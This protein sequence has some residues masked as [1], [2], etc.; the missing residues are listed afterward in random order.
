METVLSP[1]LCS[2]PMAVCGDPKNRHG[3]VLAKNERAKKYGIQTAETIWQAKRKCPELVLVLPHHSEYKKYS[4]QIN[5]IYQR[6]TDM[7]EPFGI[8]ESWL[9]VTGSQRLFGSGFEIAERLRR[10][11]REETGLTISVG[12]SF[13]KTFAKLGSDYKKPNATTVIDREN[14][15]SIV[16]PLPVESLLFVG[17]AT[18]RS[19]NDLYIKTIG[20]LAKTERNILIKRLGKLGGQLYDTANG[21]DTSPVRR[22]DEPREIKSVGNGMTFSRDLTGFDDARVG[23]SSLCDEVATRLRKQGLCAKTIQLQLKDSQLKVIS[24]QKPLDCATALS[25]ELTE[26]AVALLYAVYDGHTAIR[27]ITVTAAGLIPA[28]EAAQQLS[29]FDTQPQKREK[30]HRLESAIDSVREKFGRGAISTGSVIGS[31][32]GL[33]E[34]EAE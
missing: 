20:D 3:I 8:D 18:R 32:I 4:K 1:E 31:D 16:F 22:F 23:I 30:L 11:V 14:W 29:F 21:I 6:Y 33:E 2:V 24:R 10:E 15:Q 5:L 19:L 28:E 27:T 34:S 17:E 26:G 12:V 25:A 9:D 7:V 13:N